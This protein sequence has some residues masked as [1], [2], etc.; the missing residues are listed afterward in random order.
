MRQTLGSVV[1]SL[2]RPEYTGENRCPPCTAVNLL[3]AAALAGAL[4]FVSLPVAV[5][6]FA[7]SVATV[8]V[9]GYLVPG[10][11]TLTKR[12]LPDQ[13]LGWFDK[14]PDAGTAD[15]T[16]PDAGPGPVDP[17]TVLLDAGAV[18]ECE[19][20]NDLCLDDSFRGAWRERVAELEAEDAAREDLARVLGIDP[21]TITVRDHGN[22]FVAGFDGGRLGQWESY[23]AFVADVAA[24]NELRERYPVWADLP[25]RDR[26]RTL[27][28]LR[29]F[30]DRCPNC[31]GPVTM[32]HDT[33]ESCCR[34][35]EVV[36]ASCDDCGARFF[37]SERL[38]S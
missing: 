28:G 25:V 35:I 15:E 3:L 23:A 26:S 37:E 38:A 20:G 8:Y 7:V 1:G 4:A 21:A 14:R 29:I 24:A 16:A 19:R 34:S 30:L 5:V 2:R 32:D 22:A 33:V 13:V 9:R 36:A 31:D 18:T 17:E 6:A 12:Y 27:R 11:P 10:T